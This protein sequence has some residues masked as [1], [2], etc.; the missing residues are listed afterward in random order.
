M[1]DFII[2][3]GLVYLFM[4]LLNLKQ[5]LQE[6]KEQQTAHETLI[7]QLREHIGKLY[8]EINAL[9]TLAPNKIETDFGVIDK[10]SDDPPQ[11]ALWSDDNVTPA[12]APQTEI[13]ADAMT[14]TVETD[15]E[16]VNNQP[17][18]VHPPSDGTAST[19]DVNPFDTTPPIHRPHKRPHVADNINLSRKKPRLP[20]HLKR[21]NTNASADA[22]GQVQ[23]IHTQSPSLIGSAI[24]WLT[25]GNPLLKVG[26]G[27]L[28]LGLAFLLRFASDYIDPPLWL[29]YLSVGVSGLVA[30]GAGLYLTNKR[31]EYGLTLQG[32]GL[33]VMY[34]TTL[35]ALKLPHLI[36]P[37][38]AFV[39]MLVVMVAKIVLA[40]RQDAKLLAQ[41]AVIG[42]L[43]VPI[44][45][46][47][48]QGNHILLFTYL[49]V[50]NT[51]IAIIA[52]HKAWR[53]LNV[54]GLMGTFFIAFLWR[55]NAD[56]SKD[57]SASLIFGL[58]H[59]ALYAYI[60]YRYAQ[61]QLLA[62][63]DHG[64]TDDDTLPNNATLSQI[65]THY[66]RFG[67]QVGVLDA[68]V[69]FASAFMGFVFLYPIIAIHSGKSTLWLALAFALIYLVFALLAKRLSDV[70]AHAFWLLVGL[71]VTLGIGLGFD[72]RLATGLWALQAGLVYVFGV[73]GRLPQVR[74]FA[75]AVF[76]FASLKHFTTYHVAEYD[77]WFITGDFYGTLWLSVAG[78]AMYGLGYWFNKQSNQDDEQDEAQNTQL[79]QWERYARY[80]LLSLTI[81]H[82]FALPTL[83]LSPVMSVWASMVM[84]GAYMVW[85]YRHD[86]K[87]GVAFAPVVAMWLSIQ[88]NRLDNYYFAYDNAGRGIFASHE[89]LVGLLLLAFAFILEHAPWR[90]RSIFKPSNHW[91][92]SP[93]LL[94]SLPVLFASL[95]LMFNGVYHAMYT[96]DNGHV[97]IGWAW[98]LMWAICLGAISLANRV[99]GRYWQVLAASSLVFAPCMA[100]LLIAMSLFYSVDL[101]L[102]VV[103]VAS[104]ALSLVILAYQ[105]LSETALNILHGINLSLI[106]TTAGVLCLLSPFDWL[107]HLWVLPVLLV[108]AVCVK[109]ALP[110]TGRFVG[111]YREF[112]AWLC[113]V[114]SAL[115]TGYVAI[116]EPMMLGTR[117]P[118]I[119][120]V[121]VLYVGLGVLAYV[122]VRELY[123]QGRAWRVFCGIAGA[124]MFV[125][126]S[127]MVVR[128]WY[129]YGGVAWDWQ[130][131]FGDFGLQ[132]SLSLTWSSVAIAGMVL[133][134][135][136]QWRTLWLVSASLMG[137]VV[138]KLFVVELG[139]S[140]GVAR[141]VSFIGVG[142][143]LLLVGWFAPAPPKQVS[144]DE[145]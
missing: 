111:A 136:W 61:S 37:S 118:L 68:G 134:A 46:S 28:F 29:R 87:V 108:W 132:A 83:V 103:A 117:L 14:D 77:A 114:L 129:F 110:W 95:I 34:L 145:N 7:A 85:Q 33:A 91:Q 57:S 70:V 122:G 44:L 124:M 67:S 81:I 72:D 23:D 126:I 143:L 73:K 48:G 20:T 13:T 140:G 128:T 12:I 123:E 130:G 74:A 101:S 92:S 115:W 98:L 99:T 125:A 62:L 53:S 39:I 109:S 18:P 47:S 17:A 36:G 50:I 116:K 121:D 127:S 104:L 49:A 141:I 43:A 63:S 119:N 93:S 3:L 102:V 15:N 6:T 120:A 21:S 89:M 84:L 78:L 51:S 69:L 80:A 56:F 64:E 131:L 86:N 22:T 19:S 24:E 135:R 32:F 76:L 100:F 58:Y 27:I 42:A 66:I 133:S 113:L 112:G 35:A 97:T 60:V 26:I 11:E 25:T 96:F 4:T 30:T 65:L 75:L 2:I 45:T 82:G 107:V 8:Q 9:K 5:E 31:R 88:V 71:F 55:T 138:V 41:I 94:F 40:L 79:A 106:A 16:Q 139:N 10:I 1:L 142:L 52:T 105:R 54:I 38:T 59:V 137:V 144:D 90:Y